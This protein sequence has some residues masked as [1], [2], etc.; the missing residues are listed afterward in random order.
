MST[1]IRDPRGAPSSAAAHR[2]ER[3]PGLSRRPLD[4]HRRELRRARRQ[5][6]STTARSPSAAEAR[7]QGAGGA[8]RLRALVPGL[9]AAALRE[10]PGVADRGAE[11]QG[12]GFCPS[13][14][15]DAA[16][17]GGA[18]ARRRA[19]RGGAAGMGPPFPL[20]WR[21]TAI[22]MVQR[23]SS[24]LRLRLGRKAASVTPQRRPPPANGLQT[25]VCILR[26]QHARDRLESRRARSSAGRGP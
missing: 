21:A 10:L 25:G 16:C 20:H 12:A 17:D 9:R 7:A 22:T 19:A 26:G 15:G 14:R 3:L 18:P 13:C 23:T 6:P 2:D 1:T 5:A 24:D 4:A 8:P 11:L